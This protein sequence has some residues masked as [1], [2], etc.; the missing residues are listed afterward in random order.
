MT[1]YL[2]FREYEGFGFQSMDE[3]DFKQLL[4]RAV[5]V[6]DFVTQHFYQFTPLETDVEFRKRQFKKAVAVQIQYFHE[7]GQV[8]TAGMNAAPQSVKIGRTQISLDSAFSSVGM[9]K[10]HGLVCPDVY[11]YLQATGLLS[12]GVG[13]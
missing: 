9:N 4:P 12:R 8:T 5:E 7:L 13:G 2:S 10:R 1:A 11:V 3:L 6:L